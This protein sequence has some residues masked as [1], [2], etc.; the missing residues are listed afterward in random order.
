M[1]QR[2]ATLAA[3]ALQNAELYD[4][5]KREQNLTN[6]NRELEQFAYIVS[7]DLKAPLRGITNLVDWITEDI[8]VFLYGF[9]LL[10]HFLF[11]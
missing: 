1:A 2:V 7:H 5:F 3:N 10:I 9:H 11:Y 4:S 6:L 8:H